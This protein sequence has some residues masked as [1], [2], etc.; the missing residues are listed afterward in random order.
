MLPFDD[1]STNAM[2][3]CGLN[4]FSLFSDEAGGVQILQLAKK[5][6]RG[7]S[8]INRKLKVLFDQNFLNILNLQAI[9]TTNICILAQTVVSAGY[10]T[11]SLYLAP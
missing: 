3:H 1:I 7:E 6:R 9:A 2:R 5:E 11:P 8:L 10:L 4:I